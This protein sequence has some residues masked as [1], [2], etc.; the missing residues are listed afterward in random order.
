MEILLSIVIP[1]TR[2]AGRLQNLESWYATFNY[3]ACEVIF[4]HDVQDH[5]TSDEIKRLVHTNSFKNYHIVEGFYG[6]PGP[7]R[8][9]GLNISKGRWVTFWDSDDV[10]FPHAYINAVNVQDTSKTIVVGNYE[11]YQVNNGSISQKLIPEREKIKA[12][13][14]NPGL[15]RVIFRRDCIGSTRFSKIRMGEDQIFIAQV[16]T[17]TQ[18]ISFVDSVM[19]RYFTGSSAQLTSNIDAISDLKFAALESLSLCRSSK[20]TDFIFPSMIFERQIISGLRHGNLVTKIRLIGIQLIGF[21]LLSPLKRN[22]LIGA[23]RYIYQESFL[24]VTHE[25]D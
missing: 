21:I 7:A 3:Q 12:F 9:A 19:Y 8:N 4:V 15:W 25:T 6:G 16:L 2:M 14:M 22:Q 5:E 24:R 11:V 23:M 10:V 13:A 18:E 20:E 17:K 1:I